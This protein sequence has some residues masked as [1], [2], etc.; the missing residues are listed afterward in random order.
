MLWGTAITLVPLLIVGVVA[1]AVFKLNY[2][3]LCG[4]LAGGMT[5]PPALAFATSL[6]GSEDAAV[7]YVS[8]YPLIMILRVFSAQMLV[9]LLAS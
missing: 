7:S 9:L 5:D 2:I 4:L 6:S 1:W 3:R 8:V